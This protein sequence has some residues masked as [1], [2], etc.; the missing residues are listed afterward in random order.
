MR[1]CTLGSDPAND[2]VSLIR[3]DTS[4]VTVSH[5]PLENRR[6]ARGRWLALGSIG[7]VALAIV[8]WSRPLQRERPRFVSMAELSTAGRGRGDPYIGSRVCRDCH[9]GESASYFRSGHARTFGVA[10]SHPV[11]RQLEGKVVADPEI[12]GVTWSFAMRDGRLGVVRK[13]QGRTERFDFDYALGSAHHATTFL[14][15]L[16][17]E[18]PT[19]FEHRLTFLSRENRI[20]ITPGQRSAAPSPGTTPR[21]RELSAGETIK[22]FRCHTTQ[23]S[24]RQDRELDESTLIPN[25][26]CERCHGPARAH[27]TAARRG[28]DLPAM[29]FGLEQWTAAEQMKLCGQCHRHPSKAPPGMIRADD[30]RLARFQPVGL[31][32]SKCYTH[33]RGAMSCVNCHDPHARASADRTSYEPA[34]LQCHAA[35]PQAVCPT[36]PRTGC[37]DCHMPKVDTGQR[38][39]FTDHWIRIRRETPGTVPAPP[40]ERQ[41]EVFTHGQ[42]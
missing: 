22:C 12:S 18:K 20:I 7:L 16:N 24:A 9:P 11:V 37:V 33:S 8:V 1:A 41:P 25:V 10:E 38:V 2:Q 19:A 39:L 23:P 40:T 27:V 36:S 32:Q 15:V 4:L 42:M 6:R 31:M 29:P 13:E 35:A 28:Q 21:G 30:S 17:P 3:I 14:T 34:C 26:S 5:V